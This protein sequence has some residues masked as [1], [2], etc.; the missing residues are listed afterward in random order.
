MTAQQAFDAACERSAVAM[1]LEGQLRDVE[2]YAA[3]VRYGLALRLAGVRQ[4]GKRPRG[5]R[6]PSEKFR[7]G[8]GYGRTCTPAEYRA[9]LAACRVQA[10]E[11]RKAIAATGRAV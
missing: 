3:G 2:D 4:G 10:N 6:N 1:I 9:K 5:R 7:L 8:T 11:Y